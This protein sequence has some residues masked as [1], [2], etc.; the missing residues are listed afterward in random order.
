M[1]LRGY[2]A[3][4]MVK[5]SIVIYSTYKL[6]YMAVFYNNPFIK[7]E[8][9]ALIPTQSRWF[10]QGNKLTVHIFSLLGTGGKQII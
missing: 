7:A 3:N 4:M 1:R 6:S 8:G 2:W 10:C 5:S 9:T